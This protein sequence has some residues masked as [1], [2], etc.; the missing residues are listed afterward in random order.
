[1]QKPT[2]NFVAKHMHTYN[3]PQVVQNKRNKQLDDVYEREADEQ[4][5]QQG[6][7]E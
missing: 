1:M 2:R 6:E 4:L 7:D 5:Y 3:R